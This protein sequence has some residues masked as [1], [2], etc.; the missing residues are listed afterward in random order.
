MGIA[1]RQSETEFGIV[2]TYYGVAKREV[3]KRG[4][5]EISRTDPFKSNFLDLV[6]TLAAKQQSH[7]VVVTHGYSAGLIMPVTEKTTTSATNSILVDLV[8][9][10]EAYPSM[11]A[12]KVSAFATSASIT[13]DEV[14]ELAKI[15]RQV[16]DHDANCVALHIRGCKIGA[17]IANL[18]TL[19]KLFNSIV[20]SAPKCPMLYTPFNPMW[21]K[22]PDYDVEAW[23][24][25]NQPKSR[26]R[27]FVDTAAGRSKLVLDLD[28]ALDK[29]SAQGA[30]AHAD[31]LAKWADIIY[32]N[33]THAV[34]HSMPI[35]A[36]WPDS[37]YF[38]PHESGY[39]DQIV[40][41]RN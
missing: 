14:K 15:C 8:P 28:Y 38:L 17:D 40:A 3:T 16:R 37:G 10:V 25:A 36:M 18:D 35:A 33:K 9:L 30:I 1:L 24:T 21:H 6:R 27:E 4:D 22:N 32:A 5:L 26:R 29:G 23:K 11:D 2:D 12:A 19:R 34:Q 31:D 20:V 7:V 41:S 13:E 39:S